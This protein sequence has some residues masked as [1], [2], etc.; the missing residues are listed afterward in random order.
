MSKE[1]YKNKF[2]AEI[3]KVTSKK[4]A[5]LDIVYQVV[6]ETNDPAVMMLGAINADMLVDV[7]VETQP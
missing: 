2:V 1:H 5:S 3:R 6:L 4:T 7:T